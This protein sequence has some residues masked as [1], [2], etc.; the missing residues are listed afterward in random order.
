MT[1]QVLPMA[2]RHKHLNHSIFSFILTNNTEL[3]QSLVFGNCGCTDYFFRHLAFR[4]LQD[5]TITIRRTINW[6]KLAKSMVNA[7]V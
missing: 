2:Q 5:I 7:K 4:K 6:D 1:C 3:W